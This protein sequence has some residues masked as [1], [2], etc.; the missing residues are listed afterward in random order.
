[1][2]HQAVLPGKGLYWPQGKGGLFVC[3]FVSVSVSH[4]PELCLVGDRSFM[5]VCGID[6]VLFFDVSAA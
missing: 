5:T 4:T 6:T 1:M 3:L 2:A